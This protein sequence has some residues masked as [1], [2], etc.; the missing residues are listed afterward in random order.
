VCTQAFRLGD[1]A[2]GVQFHPE[3]TLQQVQSWVDEEKGLPVEAETLLAE[4]GERIE[5]WN[6]LGRDLCDAFVDAAE[7]VAAPV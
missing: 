6:A 2:W 7:R 1:N 5:E 3:V 4:T